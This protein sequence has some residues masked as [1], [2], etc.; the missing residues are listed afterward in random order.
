MNTKENAQ[1]VH[2]GTCHLQE[3]STCQ[4]KWGNQGKSTTRSWHGPTYQTPRERS[5]WE[6]TRWGRPTLWAGR[7]WPA[8]RP[9][10]LWR[11]VAPTPPDHL[12]YM[13]LAGT[14]LEDYKRGLPPPLTT[15]TISYVKEKSR[16]APPLCILSLGSVRGRSAEKSRTCRPLFGF[17]PLRIW[18]TWS[19]YPGSSNWWVLVKLFFCSHSFAGSSS[20]LIADTLEE[21]PW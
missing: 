16:E 5:G 11:R 17:V 14:D 2:T 21:G 10:A 4:R 12:P 9:G 18:Y 3:G 20:V 1:K 7:T 15:H 19:T 8:S 13:F 6:E